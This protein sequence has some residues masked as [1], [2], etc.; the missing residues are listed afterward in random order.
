[1]AEKRTHYLRQ[2]RDQVANS[3]DEE[4]LRTVVFD[5]DLDWDELQGTRKTA[6]VQ[7][8]IVQVGRNGRLSELVDL[9]GEKRPHINWVNVAPAE[10]QTEDAR[11][12]TKA[13][14]PFCETL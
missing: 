9:L 4:E 11:G 1:M 6:R 3:F 7:D 10:Q 5:L 14:N 12:A 2:L 8:L 13:G